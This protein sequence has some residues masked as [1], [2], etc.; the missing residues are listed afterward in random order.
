MSAFL[1]TSSV[2]P[3][4]PGY[5]VAASFGLLF[6]SLPA[7]WHFKSGNV[8]TISYI[9]W[10]FIGNLVYLVN[11]VSWKGNL[12]TPPWFW[13]DLSTALIIAINVAIPTSSLLIT[14]RLYAIST[15]RQ[16]NI[17][18][19]DSRRSKY[20]EAGVAVAFPVLAVLLRVIVQG[21]R[22]DIIE[23]VGCWPSVYITPP[24]I[25]LVFLPPILINLVSFTYAGLA[26][27]AFLKQR[28]QFSDILA[29]ANSGLSISRY[30][31]LMAL[32]ATEMMCSLP[33]SCYMLYLNVAHG[34]HPWKGW[35]DTHYN[36]NRFERLPWG[37]YKVFPKGY[38]MMNISRWSLPAGAFL[39][40]IYLGMSGESG[41]FYGRQF[42]RVA[43]VLGFRRA[44]DSS[45]AASWL[46]RPGASAPTHSL[47][48]MTTT[49]SITSTTKKDAY[50]SEY[51]PD[52]TTSKAN[53]SSDSLSLPPGFEESEKEAEAQQ[54]SVQR[55]AEVHHS[56]V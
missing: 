37:W 38:V 6:I 22:F 16:V 31:R 55:P 3:T 14:H 4:Y 53:S 17:S 44:A 48:P 43:S 26:I 11:S 12:H 20:W 39:F 52:G 27:R 34:V 28:R 8:G 41:E 46:A 51:Y 2:D 23:N 7:Y 32:A 5:P 54:N 19:S 33:A 50:S 56:V 42:W 45:P 18:K 29:S 15:I 10:T 47:P 9:V 25:P 30:F 40:F 21:H 49:G 13:C 24:S 1:T 36:F 35:A